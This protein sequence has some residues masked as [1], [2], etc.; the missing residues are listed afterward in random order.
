LQAHLALDSQAGKALLADV[1]RVALTMNG[2]DVSK[3]LLALG[4][5]QALSVLNE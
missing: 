4:K 3:S 5:L 1:P 2:Q